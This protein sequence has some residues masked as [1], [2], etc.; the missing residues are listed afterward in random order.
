MDI[1]E[2]TRQTPANNGRGYGDGSASGKGGRIISETGYG[3]GNIS[4]QG[5][6]FGSGSGMSS[7]VIDCWGYGD[8]EACGDGSGYGYGSGSGE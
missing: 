8:G 1:Q 3:C 7:G 4:E 5:D 6:C 2:F